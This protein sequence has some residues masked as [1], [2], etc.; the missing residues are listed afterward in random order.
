MAPWHTGGP[1]GGK[2][3]SL[4]PDC[5]D[6]KLCSLL[7]AQWCTLLSP[8]HSKCNEFAVHSA[9]K[10]QCPRQGVCVFGRLSI[11][12]QGIGLPSHPDSCGWPLMVMTAPR[13]CLT[14]LELL[15]REMSSMSTH[16]PCCMLLLARAAATAR[17]SALRGPGVASRFA[18]A[19]HLREA[20]VTT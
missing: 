9:N 15:C 17:L 14:L 8:V 6:L 7:A 11:L 5:A 4:L 10:T 12:E 19:S 2:S 3:T 18:L 16:W 13:Q 1:R 20:W